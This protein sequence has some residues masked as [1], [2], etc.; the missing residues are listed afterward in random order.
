MIAFLMS[1]LLCLIPSAAY[2]WGPIA[3]LD[4]ASEILR[5]LTILEPTVKAILT[6]C[7]RDFLYGAIAAD[8]TVGKKYIDTLY[9]CHNWKVGFSILHK[10]E[11]PRQKAAAYGYLAHLAADII[12]HNFF[13]PFNTIRSFRSRAR[14]HIYWEASYDAKRPDSV[15]QLAK[16]LT[17]EDFAEDDE[18]FQKMIRRTLF[19]FKT[20]KRIFGGIMT[21]HRFQ[22]WK[23]TIE[24][25]SDR[26]PLVLSSQDIHE[27][28][29][30]A[31]SNALF[32]LRGLH[33]VPSVTLDPTGQTVLDYAIRIRR[34]LR[35]AWSE[36][37]MT[38]AQ[39]E[40][41]LIVLKTR[42]HDRLMDPSLTL[43]E[44]D[45]RV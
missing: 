15:W 7:P 18:L 9:N 35:Q 8:I 21:I 36:K 45:V 38:E 37:T 39:V 20:N 26:S 27:F 40:Q 16:E 24:K 4:Y 25:I 5:N 2:A 28:R 33:S 13:V 10:A 19:S 12:S 44:L 22:R 6:Q 42:M 29:S 14:G 41:F 3:H 34:E 1:L 11:G 30:L 17:Q 23:K 32:L 31:L 43:P